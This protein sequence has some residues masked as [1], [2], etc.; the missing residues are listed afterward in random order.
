MIHFKLSFKYTFWMVKRKAI[1]ITLL[2]APEWCAS[3]DHLWTLIIVI[4]QK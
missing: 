4:V 2:L 1:N 3:G